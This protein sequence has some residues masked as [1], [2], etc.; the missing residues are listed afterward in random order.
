MWSSRFREPSV[1]EE[2]QALQERHGDVLV[3]VDLAADG[4]ELL[5][6]ETRG[7]RLEGAMVASLAPVFEAL[8]MWGLWVDRPDDRFRDLARIVVQLAQGEH[9][10][11]GRAECIRPGGRGEQ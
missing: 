4:F 7:R 10:R 9:R 2:A 1:I 8:A 11:D 5:G 6:P 3:A